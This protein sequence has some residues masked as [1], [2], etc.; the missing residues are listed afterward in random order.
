MV[1]KT[2]EKI[3]KGNY[4][5]V[6]IKYLKELLTLSYQFMPIVTY[7]TYGTVIRKTRL[8]WNVRLR[9]DNV[10][11]SNVVR[12]Q[13][14]HQI[15][16]VIETGLS[17]ESGWYEL[18]EDFWFIGYGRPKFRRRRTFLLRSMLI[19]SYKKETIIVG[20]K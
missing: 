6:L 15:D 8:L 2:N 4:T 20:R 1:K 16:F 10:V 9:Q 18:L 12:R 14:F 13:L 3:K 19:E 11:G 5:L 17:L 7:Y